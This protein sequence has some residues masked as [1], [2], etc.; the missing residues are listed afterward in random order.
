[1]S[2]IIFIHINAICLLVVTAY[3]VKLGYLINDGK[4]SYEKEM[5][6]NREMNI[7]KIH[8]LAHNEVLETYSM[9]NFQKGQ[10]I[11]CIPSLKQC[12]FRENKAERNADAN[13]IMETFIISEAHSTIGG[14][15]FHVDKD[16]MVDTIILE[17]HL[18]EFYHGFGFPLYKENEIL[19]D[20]KIFNIRNLK[21]GRRVKRALIA[22]PT[23]C[24]GQ[25]PT[26]KYGIS[27]GTSSNRLQM[28]NRVGRLN[29]RMVFLDC[30]NVSINSP[31]AYMCVCCPYVT[32]IDT[33]RN[34]CACTRMA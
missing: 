8:T 33:T 24:Y 32:Y 7:L 2:W 31:R 19:N 34:D 14:E 28:C 30:D 1:M 12:I 22:F 4:A 23:E 21:T 3:D 9:Q 5:E 26:M 16:E 17:E 20:A 6:T 11:T 29:G 27:S 18:R 10:Q 15:L 25:N 13:L